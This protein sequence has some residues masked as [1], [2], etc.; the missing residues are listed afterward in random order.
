MVK[1]LI[2]TF[3]PMKDPLA[4]D[5]Q[6]HPLRS[7]E[8]TKIDIWIKYFRQGITKDRVLKERRG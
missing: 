1:A 3:F 4:L 8:M 5:M 6:L 7:W 2:Q